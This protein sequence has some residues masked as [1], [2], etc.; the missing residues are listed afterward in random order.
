M[1]KY[2]SLTINQALHYRMFRLE[3][4]TICCLWILL[5]S[6]KSQ[7]EVDV[8]ILSRCWH[9][10]I[11]SSIAILF[12]LYLWQNL[13]NILW[14]DLY[15]KG[16][17]KSAQKVARMMFLPQKVTS[18]QISKKKI[19]FL[20]SQAGVIL[21]YLFKLKFSLLSSS[22]W[23]QYHCYK[24]LVCLKNDMYYLPN[25]KSRQL[26]NF[27]DDDNLHTFS[28]QTRLDYIDYVQ[29]LRVCES[30]FISLIHFDQAT[31]GLKGQGM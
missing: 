30:L 21:I 24:H 16:N 20:Q 8:N 31:G 9:A 10:W 2:L 28:D 5:A 26:G 15:A 22:F 25:S 7:G 23:E 29:A 6:T 14:A 3:L 11:S 19:N 1:E 12:I 13:V 4:I 18:F 17:L 27:S